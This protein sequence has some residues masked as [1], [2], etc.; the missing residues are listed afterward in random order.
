MSDLFSMLFYNRVFTTNA[1]KEWG[2]LSSGLDKTDF[3]GNVK[4]KLA[5]NIFDISGD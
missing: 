2:T 3:I 1:L 5:V 4:T